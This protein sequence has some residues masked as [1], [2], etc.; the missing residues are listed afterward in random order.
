MASVTNVNERG[1]GSLEGVT[2]VGIGSTSSEE[3]CLEAGP[4]PVVQETGD[5]KTASELG[6]ETRTE[7]ASEAPA[8]YISDEENDSLSESI[9][10]S[11]TAFLL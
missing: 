11:G 2:G 7:A 8:R 5:L 4:R 9:G 10:H 1:A 3:E 6:A